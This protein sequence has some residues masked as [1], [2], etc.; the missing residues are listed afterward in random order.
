MPVAAGA[1]ASLFNVTC[2][3]ANN[4]QLLAMLPGIALNLPVPA[5]SDANSPAN[6]DLAGHHYF[7]DSTTPYFN[8]D[9]SLHTWG[10]GPFSK[11]ASVSAPTDA[12]KGP[13]GQGNGAVSWLQLNTKDAECN[14]QQVYRV[15]T[16]GG[17]PPATCQGQQ[18]AFQV[19]YAAEYWISTLR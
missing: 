15:N 10:Q 8:L 5:S 18:A 16:A 3:A 2:M 13:F 1:L 19:Q 11:I 9:T 12:I 4:P 6:K 7:L 14:L 17:N